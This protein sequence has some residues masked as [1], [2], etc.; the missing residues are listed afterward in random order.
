MRRVALVSCLFLS[1]SSALARGRRV[2][3]VLARVPSIDEVV[4]KEG[5][6]PTLSQSETY[7]PGVVLVPNA[8]GGHDEVIGDCVGVEPTIKIMA[9]SSIATSLSAGVSARL[10]A[11]RGEVAAGVE[12]RLSFVDPEQRTIPLAELR[13]TEDCAEG[14]NSRR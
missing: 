6:V 2:E 12:K 4:A 7:H 11:V 8:Q 3:P 5:F 1:S 14:L 9:Q 10:S 13:A